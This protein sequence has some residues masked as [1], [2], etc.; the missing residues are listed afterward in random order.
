[1]VRQKSRR[2]STEI[3]SGLIRKPVTVAAIVGVIL[4]ML[5][6][7]LAPIIAPHDPYQRDVRNKLATPSSAHPLGTDQLGRDTLSRLMYGARIAVMITFPTIGLSLVLGIITGTLVGF[8]PKL[9]FLI[10]P[11]LDILKAFPPVVLAIAI[12][13]LFGGSTTKLILVMA[14]TWFP[15][16]ARVVRSQIESIQQKEYVEAARVL[17]A[18]NFR[19]M[20]RH[21]LPNAISPLIILAA[22]DI[23]VIISYEAALSFLGL[24]IP[25]PAP[26][27]G[28]DSKQWI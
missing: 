20:A 25:P 5:V 9:E 12:I 14:V 2:R 24:G 18:S 16:Y 10:S 4:L 26:S 3:F 8:F 6:A 1:M 28:N 13:G 11:P 27:W 21:V 19:I 15:T 17:G 7:A 23:P 22:M